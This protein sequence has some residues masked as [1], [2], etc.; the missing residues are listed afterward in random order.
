MGDLPGEAAGAVGEPAADAPAASVVT[1][2]STWR[3]QW[4][5][6]TMGVL[7]RARRWTRRF[8]RTVLGTVLLMVLATALLSQTRRG[9]NFALDAALSRVESVVAGELSVDSVRSGTLLTGATLVGF[10]LETSDGR[11][12]ATADSVEL[13][14]SLPAAIFGGPPI[15][16]TIIWG[17]DLEISSYTTDQ[18][19]NITQLLVAGQPRDPG[20]PAATAFSLGRVGIRDGKVRIIAPAPDPSHP[21]VVSGPNGEPLRVLDFDSLDLD[22]EEAVLSLDAAEQ[23]SARLAS[24]S[25]QISILAEPIRV[26]E[27]FGRLAYS[28]GAGVDVT[29]LTFRLAAGSLLE[30]DIAVG[31]ES[32]GAPWTFRASLATDGWADLDDVRWV[33]PRVPEGRYRGAA[34]LRTGGGMLIELHPLEVELEASQMVFDGPV[35]FGEE[36]SMQNLNVSANP[37]TLERLEPWLQRELPI[38]GWL[39]GDAVFSGTLD[40][41]EAEGRVT[42]VPTGYSGSPVTADFFG[43]IIQGDNPGARGLRATLDPLNYTILEALWPGVP[44]GGDGFGTIDIDGRIDD[45]MHVAASL[46]H[47]SGTGLE[48]NFDVRG[49]VWRGL[50]VGDWITSLDVDL[51]PL[52]IGVFSSLAPGLDLRGS[53][54]GPLTL[55]GPLNDLRVTADLIAGSGTILFDGA[56]DVTDPAASYRLRA[57]G[58]A[59]PLATVTGRIPMETVWSGQLDLEGTGFSADSMELSASLVAMQSQVGLVRVDTF[60]TGVRVSHGVLIADSLFGNVA[61]I[62][63]DGGGRLGLAAGAFG[64]ARISFAGSSLVGFR[65]LLMGV[66]DDVTVRDTLSALD[67]EFLRFEGADPD[68]LPLERD[69]A[70]R[71]EVKGAANISG[72]LRDLDIG[73]IVDVFDLAY[74][75]NQVDTVRVLF[76]ATS[77]PATTGEW[78]IGAS[79]KGIAWGDRVFERGGFEADMFE[80]GGEGRI[81]LVRR[82]GEKYRA[83]GDFEFDSVGSEIDLTEAS[84]QVDELFWDLARPGRVAWD[85]STLTVDSLEI[86]RTD[87]DPMTMMVDGTLARGG[88]SDFHLTID[89]LH[90]EKVL[91]VAQREDL[92]VGGHVALDV[93][94]HGPSE[95][96]LIEADFAVDGGRYGT[97]E[98]SRFDGS[99]TYENRGVDFDIRGWDGAADVLQASGLF[100]VDL[101]LIDVE[102]R[103]VDAPMAVQI[104]ADSLDAAIALS[105]VRSLEGVLG[106]VSGEV[107]IRGTPVDP[108]PE[109]T[110]T[111][112]DGEWSVEAIGVR[113]TA[114]NGDVHLRPDRTVDVA[115]TSTGTGRSEVTG[116][117]LLMPVRDPVLDL[118]FA[119]DHFLAVDRP[120]IEGLVSGSFLLGGTYRRPLASGDIRVDEGTIYV[121]ELQR[122]AGVVNLNDPF[123]FDGSMAVDTTALVAQPLLAGFQNPFFDNLRVSVNMSVPR[124]SWLRSIE[125]NVELSGDLL[126][127]YDRSASDFVLIGNLE[128]VRGSHLVLGR[129]FEV[130]GGAVRFIGRPGMNPDLDIQATSRIRRPNDA[131]FVVNAQVGGSLVQPVVTLTTEETGLAEEDLVSYLIFGQPSGSLGGR[132]GAEVGQIQRSNAVNSIG[133]G[134]VTYVGGAFANQFG[135]A[136][137]RELFSL[138]YFS[139]QQQGGTQSLGAEGQRDTQI[140][141]GRYVGPDAFVVMVIRPFDTGSQNAVAGVRVEWALTDDYN[142]EGF[143]EDRFLRS[144]SQLLGSSNGLLENERILGVF[145]FREWGYNP[146]RDD[147]P[148]L[149]NEERD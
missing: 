30:G 137:A 72:E 59:L 31:P 29:E 130:D 37:I 104:V 81:E 28:K 138:D 54:A 51:L 131:P 89:G 66:G 128:A 99:L 3:T 79:A 95:A 127:V 97:M 118:T 141:L 52:S 42:L 120:D 60:N 116:T 67:L 49:T 13:R 44:W 139:V 134:L 48:S 47:L 148:Q 8:W 109:G 103:I 50:E 17:L 25:S 112:S 70:L 57:T 63:V 145:F 113:H 32:E 146:G 90:I 16:S 68:T 149:N 1:D 64:S 4:R 106:S 69:V 119:F 10:Q 143:F 20:A 136:I 34:T 129:A 110:L 2:S 61:G 76:T 14:Y 144:G 56:M 46:N 91:E 9:Q 71:G 6:R 26:S 22:V 24:F 121:D 123:L 35:R 124:G 36:I 132:N 117:V 11:P 111:L 126:V 82:Q 65:P 87:D 18:P 39:S 114:V 102:D 98:L 55:D 40:E 142:V 105:Y 19:T 125:S 62:E 83:V 58:D 7:A 38:E 94:I 122:A 77:L 108:E 15:R 107:S 12:F 74:Q 84:V 23:F 96:P 73:V 33:D 5:R 41:L 133:G 21:L 45:G 85:G 88:E 27:A 135:T 78:Q 92:A 75:R 147:P 100:P 115:L 43:T 101:S 86:I 80:L 53:V 140:E 93:E